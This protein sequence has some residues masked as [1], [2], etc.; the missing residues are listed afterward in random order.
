MKRSDIDPREKDKRTKI[1]GDNF[2][3]VGE[4]VDEFQQ[5]EGLMQTGAEDAQGRKWYDKNAF[6]QDSVFQ[7]DY[8]DVFRMSSL[9]I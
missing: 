2:Q 9:R 3:N 6:D 8:S 4:Q 7:R 1:M 5:N